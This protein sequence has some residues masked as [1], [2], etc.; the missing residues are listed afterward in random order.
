MRQYLS[1]LKSVSRKLLDG[2]LFG[3]PTRDLQ[4]GLATQ[5][6]FMLETQGGVVPL[7]FRRGN[8]DT[9]LINFHGAVDKTKRTLPVFP[10]HFPFGAPQP[11]QLAISDPTMLLPGEFGIGWYAGHEGFDTQAAV[12]HIVRECAQLLGGAPQLIFTGGSAGGFAAL[13]ASWH[14]N[15]SYAVVAGAQTNLDRY[16]PSR[17]P[18]YRKAAWPGLDPAS[19][20]QD[21]TCANLCK[22]YTNPLRNNVVALYSAGDR[23]HVDRHMLPFAG[24]MARHRS[25]RFVLEC[26]YWGIEGHSGAVPPMMLTDWLRAI[27]FNPGMAPTAL[28]PAVH[29][30]RVARRVA[31]FEGGGTPDTPPSPAPPSPAQTAPAATAGPGF[32]PRDIDTAARLARLMAGQTR[33]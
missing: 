31:G 21:V 22:L 3:V 32:A 33:P 29:D 2:T 6:P 12:Q 18:G 30:M 17:L 5:R 26:G 9:L 4:A 27:V 13:E 20:L 24:I 25:E 11:H 15:D 8:T 16:G 1:S 19:P 14:F 28:L 23:G 10:P 7:N